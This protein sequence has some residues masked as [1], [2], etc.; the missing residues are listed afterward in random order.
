MNVWCLQQSCTFCPFSCVQLTV[1]FLPAPPDNGTIIT[2][3]STLLLTTSATQGLEIWVRCQQYV[4]Q[5][6]AGVLTLLM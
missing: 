4:Q 5:M 1:E 6:G 3:T 2:Y